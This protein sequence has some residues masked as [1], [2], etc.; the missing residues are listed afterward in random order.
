MEKIP[1][2]FGWK[3]FKAHPAPWAGALST[4]PGCSSLA[5]DIYTDGKPQNFSKPRKRPSCE[6]QRL[7]GQLRERLELELLFRFTEASSAGAADC[8]GLSG[9]GSP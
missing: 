1:D 2:W 9:L 4:I 6:V 8:R 7:G 3:G 5:W